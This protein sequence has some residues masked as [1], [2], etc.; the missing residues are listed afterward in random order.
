MSWPLKSLRRKFNSNFIIV[1]AVRLSL[2]MPFDVALKKITGGLWQADLISR[3]LISHF[4]PFL[5]LERQHVRSCICALLQRDLYHEGLQCNSLS[6]V[7][8]LPKVFIAIIHYVTNRQSYVPNTPDYSKTGCKRSA[9]LYREAMFELSE[10]SS[11]EKEKFISD[12]I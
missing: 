3:H 6:T 9:L 11:A 2:C 7:S 10:M 12:N 8:V 4:I 1:E 5:P